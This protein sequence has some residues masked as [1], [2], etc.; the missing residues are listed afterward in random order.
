VIS[1]KEHH[2]FSDKRVMPPDLT[3]PAVAGQQAAQITPTPPARALTEA[4]PTASA[5]Q[6]PN[7]SLRLDHGLGLVVIEFHDHGGE[8]TRSIPSQRQIDA[9]RS[10]RIDT[11]PGARAQDPPPQPAETAPVPAIPAP[12]K[13]P[14]QDTD[15][16]P[17]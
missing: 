7:P 11:L 14:P 15:T 4:A 13:P 16:S 5:P 12:S 2:P 3:V 10:H 1:K 6:F 8:V 17:A 9:Y